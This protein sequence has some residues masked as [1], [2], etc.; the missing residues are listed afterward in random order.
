MIKPT[1]NFKIAVFNPVGYGGRGVAYAN[2]SLQK[3]ALLLQIVLMNDSKNR[4]DWWP[5]F[6][7][8]FPIF[9]HLSV[10]SMNRAVFITTQIVQYNKSVGQL[11]STI[12]NT[13]I[14]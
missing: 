12:F 11:F 4:S 5:P 8:Q 3:S 6:T 13:W 1:F 10:Q 9:V 7:L 14:E 2:Q